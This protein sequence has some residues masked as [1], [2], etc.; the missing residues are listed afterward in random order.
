[1]KNLVVFDLDGTLN[2]T[3]LY[4][5]R[6]HTE[7]LRQYGVTHLSEEEIKSFF[8]GPAENFCR[9]VFPDMDD[10]QVRGYLDVVAAFENEYI[11][12][13]RASFDGV[14]ELLDRL[15][16]DGYLLA[17]CS[18]ASLRYITLVLT[19][20]GLI[21]KIDHIQNIV[22]G[23]AKTETLAMLLEKVRPDNAVMVGDRHFDLEAAKANHLP[24]IGCLY[25]FAPEE[26]RQADIAVERAGDIYD[27]VRKLMPNA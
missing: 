5:V 6:A 20:L 12:E 22:P 14:P 3:D 26:M 8:G 16:T 23:L 1:M 11:K 10:K 17:V 24:F 25:G 13:Y 2:R 15:H 19:E 4:A 27:A 18:N 9:H 21:R 7:A